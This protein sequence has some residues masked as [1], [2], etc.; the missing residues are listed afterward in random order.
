M[1][2]KGILTNKEKY[3][4]SVARLG[5]SYFRAA[6]QRFRRAHPER[7]LQDQ[8]A[9][10]AKTAQAVRELKEQSPCMDCGQRFPACAM[11]FDHVGV[12][13]F[14]I[15]TAISKGKAI[16]AVLAEIKNCEL[17]CANC[18]R[19]RTFNRKKAKHGS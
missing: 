19:I 13:N 1:D 11:D 6:Q 9:R 12:K 4:A 8:R 2:N 14:A 17:V 10:R 3:Q 5:H 16:K 15:A 7:L 18:H